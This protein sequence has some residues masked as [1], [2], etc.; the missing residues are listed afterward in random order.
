MTADIPR[1]FLDDALGTIWPGGQYSFSVDAEGIL[2]VSYPGRNYQA[3]GVADAYHPTVV[4]AHALSQFNRH[5]AC[6]NE[7]ARQSFIRHADWLVRNLRSFD[8]FHAWAFDFRWRSPGYRCNPPWISS[9]TQGMGLSVLVRSWQLTGDQEH[10]AAA[11]RALLAFQIPISKG[12]LRRDEPPGD[13]WY[14]GT[15]SPIGAQVLNEVLFALI[16]LWEMHQVTQNPRCRQLFDDG[17]DTVRR[18]LNDFDL[19]TFLVKW[20]RYDNKLLFYSGDK[21]HRIQMEQLRWLHEA[22]QDAVIG[23]HFEKWRRW[24]DTYGKSPPS[25]RKRFFLLAWILYAT[26]LNLY[27]KFTQR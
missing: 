12:G 8:G 9:M 27:T 11:E 13:V 3:P 1:Y 2:R 23:E 4:S 16:G 19:H 6:A 15:P 17:V 20:S 21:Y 18:H 14:E 24:T 7:Q 26:L 5:A 10:I 25:L 22:T